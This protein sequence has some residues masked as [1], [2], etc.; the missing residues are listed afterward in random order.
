MLSS[1]TCYLESELVEENSIFRKSKSLPVLK[2]DKPTILKITDDSGFLALVNAHTY[3]SFVSRNWTFSQLL[4]HFVRE[5]NNDHLIIWSTGSENSWT[6]CFVEQPSEK[7][8]FREFT[9]TME[10][11]D[12]KL[13]L[14]N[15]EDLTM[16]AQCEQ[17]E[18]PSSHHADLFIELDNGIY[19]LTVR[20][21]FD[22]ESYNLESDLGFEIVIRP[23]ST[24]E[25]SS[26]E[27]IVWWDC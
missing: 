26:I 12:R 13:F 22:P 17:E 6:V 27:K 16:A 11:T 9:K 4:N 3:K 18:L 25:F 21:L 14:T 10:V 23:G 24:K 15:Y 7:S 5:M 8:S 19:E 1:N 2:M 20:Q